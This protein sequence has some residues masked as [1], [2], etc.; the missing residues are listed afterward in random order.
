[1]ILLCDIQD[2]FQNFISEF[3]FKLTKNMIISINFKLLRN[4][5]LHKKINLIK[6]VEL[7]FLF[8]SQ[9]TFKL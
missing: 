2:K 3:I 7:L 6:N 1:M 4:L 8:I 9:F 5:I